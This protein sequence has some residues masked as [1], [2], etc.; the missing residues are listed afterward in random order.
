MKKYRRL[1]S[2]ASDILLERSNTE[3]EPNANQI[4]IVVGNS[5]GSQKPKAT[6]CAKPEEV[7][8]KPRD[9]HLGSLGGIRE[10]VY[11]EH[12]DNSVIL[13]MIGEDGE[14]AAVSIYPETY[15]TDELMEELVNET[16]AG[17][18]FGRMPMVGALDRAFT[19]K[20]PWNGALHP[21]FWNND[22]MK[23]WGAMEAE[24]KSMANDFIRKTGLPKEWIEDII[25]K[26]SLATYN[27]TPTSDIDVQIILKYDWDKNPDR[28]PKDKHGTLLERDWNNKRA[29]YN[30]SSGFHLA[31]EQFP[32][33]FFLQTPKTNKAT[34]ASARWSLMKNDWLPG[35]KP[36]PGKPGTP[37]KEIER[38]F[39]QYYDQVKQTYF[40]KLKLTNLEAA[41]AAKKELGFISGNDRDTA[42]HGT[43]ENPAHLTADID[44]P[45]NLA[46]KALKRTK[47]VAFIETEIAKARQKGLMDLKQRMDQKGRPAPKKLN[48]A[49]RPMR[50]GEA[51][52]VRLLAQT[53]LDF[54][55][56]AE[57]RGDLKTAQRHRDHHERLMRTVRIP[58]REANM[59]EKQKRAMIAQLQAQKKHHT[60]KAVEAKNAAM[61]A[62]KGHPSI[63]DWN[64]QYRDH[65]SEIDGINKKL[66]MLGEDAKELCKPHVSGEN[67]KSKSGYKKCGYEN[68]GDEELVGESKVNFNE[69]LL[70]NIQARLKDIQT[71]MM[72]HK[73][74]IDHYDRKLAASKTP[75]E[76][77]KHRAML[78]HHD[79]AWKK[80]REEESRLRRWTGMKLEEG[81]ILNA[82]PEKREADY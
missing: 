47:L 56:E 46:F 53:H 10:D 73:S 43:A 14:R 35:Y 3:V 13:G 68:K 63:A 31:K 21:E 66:N 48:E 78:V 39:K 49:K 26:G 33:E 57:A 44:S 6:L 1:T 19:E 9:P 5:K 28:D 11:V 58:I 24:M 59:S 61:N 50:D 81:S 71:R 69:A 17:N 7:E 25:F 30:K 32:V 18:T 65:Q 29:E 41:L 82:S 37:P 77:K 55:K 42:L 80:A 4:K 40:N 75:E 70:D 54:A 36:S 45:A 76:R 51:Q 8:I 23:L 12:Y 62:P 52:Q 79:E 27:Y 2:I 20:M 15:M 60:N 72:T 34:G 22:T 74:L 67:K 38:H 64:R 16:S